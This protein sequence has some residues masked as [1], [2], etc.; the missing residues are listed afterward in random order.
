MKGLA[1]MN[2]RHATRVTFGSILV[3]CVFWVDYERESKEPHR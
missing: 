1:V 2:T 3:S